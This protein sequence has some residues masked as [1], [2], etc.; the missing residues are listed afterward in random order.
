MIAFL[1][2]LQVAALWCVGDVADGPGDIDACVALL[3]EHD[4][5]TV[6]GNHDRW[7][8]EGSAI[9]SEPEAHSRAL[10]SPSTHEFLEKLPR[11]RTFRS[12]AG[13]DVVLCHGL[14][15]NDM[16]KIGPDDYGY[17]LEVDDDLH[18][19]LADG[20]PRLIVKGH[21]HRHAIWQLER[22]TLVDAGTL[23]PYSPTC[24][25]VLDLTDAPNVRFVD[26]RDN[27]FELTRPIAIPLAP[28]SLTQIPS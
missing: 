15:M 16:S 6:R 26:R 1:S 8:V 21:S 11:A 18:A 23:L 14:G 3:V 25:A 4:V 10:I 5:L 12:N 13:L 2:D 19:L 20:H 28:R 17:G 27:G 7:L 9:R 24:G 22:L